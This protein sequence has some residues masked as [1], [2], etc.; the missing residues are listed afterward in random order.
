MSIKFLCVF[1]NELSAVY[2]NN[3]LSLTPESFVSSTG[4]GVSKVLS[5]CVLN[6]VMKR[7]AGTLPGLHVRGPCGASEK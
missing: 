2:G 4:L 3:G 1:C 5:K 6:D 7:A